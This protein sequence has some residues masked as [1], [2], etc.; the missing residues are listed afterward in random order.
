MTPLSSPWTRNIWRFNVFLTSNFSSQ[1]G[2]DLTVFFFSRWTSYLCWLSLWLSKAAWHTLQTVMCFSCFSAQCFFRAIEEYLKKYK[3]W[4]VCDKEIILKPCSLLLKGT[5]QF[6]DKQMI[7]V[8]FGGFFKH[9]LRWSLSSS[10]V[11]NTLEHSTQS[12]G[13]LASSFAVGCTYLMWSRQPCQF[14]KLFPHLS[15]V[16]ESSVCSSWTIR[17]CFLYFFSF[18]CFAPHFLQSCNLIS[19][20]SFKKCA[21]LKY[22]SALCRCWSSSRFYCLLIWI[23]SVVFVLLSFSSSSIV[24]SSAVALLAKS[25]FLVFFWENCVTTIGGGGTQWFMHTGLF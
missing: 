12:H 1:W 19:S 2:H 20:A 7:Q 10:E 5:Y 6:L 8:K 21:F 15:Q 24:A 3:Y 17:K 4:R 14:V 11:W 22:F 23:H 16:G 18:I 13:T 25:H 9:S